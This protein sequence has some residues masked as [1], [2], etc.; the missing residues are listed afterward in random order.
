FLQR[1]CQMYTIS[2]ASRKILDILFLVCPHK[3]KSTDVGPGIDLFSTQHDPLVPFRHRLLDSFFGSEVIMF[4]IDI[5]P[6]HSLPDFKS[7]TQWFQLPTDQLKKGCF[8]R[9]VGSYD[10]YDTSWW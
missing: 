4:L 8:T 2:L 7:S 1:E 3:V 9:T 10:P 5:R 6:L